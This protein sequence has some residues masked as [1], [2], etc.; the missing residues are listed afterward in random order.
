[1]S[2]NSTP[3][4]AELAPEI[5]PCPFCAGEIELIGEHAVWHKVKDG[6]LCPLG[7]VGIEI[8]QWNRRPASPPSVGGEAEAALPAGCPQTATMVRGKENRYW[9]YSIEQPPE[10]DKIIVEIHPVGTRAALRRLAPATQA[11]AR[12][13][14]EWLKNLRRFTMIQGLD[15]PWP[16]GEYVRFDEVAQLAPAPQ[17]GVWQPIETAP[18]DNFHIL[19]FGDGP[20][21]EEC[22]Y[23]MS[24]DRFQEAWVPVGGMSTTHFLPTHWM[25]LPSSPAPFGV[26]KGGAEG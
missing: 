7:Y 5:K 1:M 19:G 13:D 3:Q 8:T 9:F 22:C 18:K 16:A 15:V 14:R 6:L 21:I 24:W 26:E 25:P 4:G 11:T 12:V 2:D 10:A 20:S 17:A 23:T